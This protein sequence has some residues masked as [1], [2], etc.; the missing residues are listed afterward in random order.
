MPEGIT[1]IDTSF[2]AFAIVGIVLL[3]S[4]R[5]ALSDTS[6]KDVIAHAAKANSAGKVHADLSFAR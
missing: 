5:L 6:A 3:G 4:R 2:S 1:H